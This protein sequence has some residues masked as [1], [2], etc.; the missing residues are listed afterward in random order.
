MAPLS[1]AATAAVAQ[2]RPEP[3][4]AA[5]PK[6]KALNPMDFSYVGGE[7]RRIAVFIVG[8]IALLVVLSFVLH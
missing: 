1:A 6:A 2:P 8:M 4:P 3:R 7:L 5:T